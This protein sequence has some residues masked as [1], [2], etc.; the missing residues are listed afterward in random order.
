MMNKDFVIMLAAI[1]LLLFLYGIDRPDAT[2]R[3]SLNSPANIS[4]GNN[5]AHFVP[6]I[7]EWN[8]SYM[9]DLEYNKSLHIPANS[10]ENWTIWKGDEIAA[11]I[12][13]T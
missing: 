8:Q 9:A 1:G 7:F 2:G 5:I 10:T 3:V 6:G 4:V 11:Y 12:P 13:A